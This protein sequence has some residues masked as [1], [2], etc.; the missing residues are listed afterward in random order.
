MGAASCSKW[1]VAVKVGDVVKGV[2][3]GVVDARFDEVKEAL[4]AQGVGLGVEPNEA[5]FPTP[6][7]RGGAAGTMFISSLYFPGFLEL[8]ETALA[9][10]FS[11]QIEW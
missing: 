2:H 9:G 10:A 5:L 11:T 7:T 1:S 3:R 4:D 8:V 6:R